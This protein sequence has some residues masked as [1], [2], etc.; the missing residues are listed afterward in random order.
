M[1]DYII[2][3]AGISGLNLADKILNKNPKL[4]IELFDS[5]IRVGG[6][7][8]TI[9]DKYKGKDETYE[10]GA[11]RYNDGH[12]KLH[13]LIKRFNLY[14]NHIEIS[15]GWSVLGNKNSSKVKFSDI[16]QLIEHLI[17][18]SKNLSHDELNKLTLEKLCLK[19][20]D[21]DHVKFLMENHPFNGEITKLNCSQAI[22]M[23]SNDLS[24][25]NK[26]F[27]LGGGLSQITDNLSKE[28][29]KNGGKIN[30]NQRLIKVKYHDKIF[31][32][33][34]DSGESHQTK[35]LVLALDGESLINLVKNKKIE[36]LNKMTSEFNSIIPSSLLRTYCRYPD[37]WF[38]NFGKV[39]TGSPIKFIIPINPDTGL[40]MSSYTDGDNTD[41]WVK[42]IGDDEKQIKELHKQTTPLVK[43]F[44]KDNKPISLPLSKPLWVRNYLWSS[45]VSF[46]KPDYDIEKLY[47]KIMKP[48]KIPLFIC[49]DSYS[50]RQGW[51]EGALE[52]S[53]LVFDKISKNIS[54]N[55]KKRKSTIKGK[56]SHR[57]G[58]K[59]SKKRKRVVRKKSSSKKT[60]SKKTGEKEYTM[61]EV[62][63]HDKP[64]DAWLVIDGNVY[65]VTKFIPHHPGLGAIFNGVGKDAT[66][67]FHRNPYHK[68]S[69]HDKLKTLYIG[70]LKK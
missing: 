39:V 24:E 12:Q 61:E 6:R 13:K 19:V 31:T 14:K 65:D 62:K 49:G 43:E 40:I 30:L 55:L 37:G 26:F 22:K 21:K 36:P 57:G 3:G 20:L 66:E 59:T 64:N 17:K 60:V 1:I 44:N 63:K 28:I 52:T 46:W 34:F 56:L 7:V 33:L 9:T 11:A 10:A 51:M 53:D 15:S 38:K 2:I 47:K 41:Y 5:A 16:H 23:F 45:G 48:L 42:Y 8:H 27:V 29:K 68:K 18:E 35:N 32:C 25:R 54:G 58:R 70:K 69:S 67:I 4:H 50:L